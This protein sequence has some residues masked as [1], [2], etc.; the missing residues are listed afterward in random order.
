[1][2]TP[3]SFF[4]ITAYQSV[5][6]SLSERIGNHGRGGRSVSPTRPA[7]TSCLRVATRPV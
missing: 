1:M 7:S 5:D 2:K 4:L 3:R 6:A